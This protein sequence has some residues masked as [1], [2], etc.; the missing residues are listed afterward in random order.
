[1]DLLRRFYAD[2]F[3]GQEVEIVGI[4]RYAAWSRPHRGMLATGRLDL[5]FKH[6]AGL[7]D[8]VDWKTAAKA[9]SEE[10]MAR[11]FQ[12]AFYR[13]L[14]VGAFAGLGA[15]RTRVLFRYVDP[16]ITVTSEFEQED[17]AVI[18]DLVSAI[19]REI[20]AATTRWRGGTPLEE[21]FPRRPS[22]QC[23]TCPIRLSCATTG[24]VNLDELE[25]QHG[26]IL[27]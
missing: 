13:S 6:P 5:I 17:F 21:A 18:W 9:I 2:P 24:K 25:G 10:E 1:M 15:E 8:V 23:L 27:A 12:T 14:A 26:P 16:G 7:L 20:V 11:D 19:A 22:R 4:E 3:P